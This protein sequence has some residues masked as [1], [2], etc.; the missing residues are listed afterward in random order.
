LASN[1]HQWLDPSGP[2]SPSDDNQR[3]DPTGDESSSEV[4]IVTPQLKIHRSKSEVIA[5]MTSPRKCRQQDVPPEPS[6]SYTLEPLHNVPPASQLPLETQMEFFISLASLQRYLGEEKDLQKFSGRI[7][8]TVAL[9]RYPSPDCLQHW[10]NS[11]SSKDL[12]VS[13]VFEVIAS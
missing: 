8:Q 7:Q 13:S 9:N 5:Y 1:V 12:R 2:N 4:V 3:L 6:A 11:N 10:I